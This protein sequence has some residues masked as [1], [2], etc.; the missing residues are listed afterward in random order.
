[1]VD[2]LV[3]FAVREGASAAEV[4]DLLDSIRGLKDEV[5]GVVD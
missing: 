1:M 3:L 5:P 2:H 4:E